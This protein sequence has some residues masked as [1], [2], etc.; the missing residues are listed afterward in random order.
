MSGYHN[1]RILP[2]IDFDLFPVTLGTGLRLANRI[3][4]ILPA[5][6][7]DL[8]PVTLGTGLCLANR[9]NG[10]LPSIVFDLFRFSETSPTA[11]QT[12][13]RKV[14]FGKKENAKSKK[15]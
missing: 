5:I 14:A 15:I 4:G 6:V 8:F 1:Q 9:I 2:S 13:F 3:N 10:I 7:F 12:V 11:N